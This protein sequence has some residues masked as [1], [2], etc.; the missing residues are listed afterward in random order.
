M[1]K[2]NKNTEINNPD[3]KLNISDVINFIQTQ[4]VKHNK[5]IGYYRK[6]LADNVHDIKICQEYVT[7]I[8]NEE[9]CII[10]CKMIQEYCL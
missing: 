7:I 6:L 8:Q 10:E 2:V 5:N 4:V 3:K 1:E 9:A